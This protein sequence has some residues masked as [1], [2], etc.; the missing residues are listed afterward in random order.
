MAEPLVPFRKHCS[1]DFICFEDKH[2]PFT[3]PLCDDLPFFLDEAVEV[4]E[5]DLHP[6]VNNLSNRHKVLRDFWDM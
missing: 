2:P 1:S 3:M 5:S 4:H 6:L